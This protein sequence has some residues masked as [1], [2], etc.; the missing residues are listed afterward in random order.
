M[1]VLLIEDNINKRNAI[2]GF[3]CAAFPEDDFFTA[4][5]LISGLKSARDLEPG[6]ILLDMSL[7]NRANASHKSGPSAT[8]A[9]A[10]KEFLWRVKRM[11]FRTHVLV[12]SMFETFGVSPNIIT[13]TDLD[14]EMKERYPELYVSAVHYS[15]SDESWQGEI[16][17]FRSSLK[18]NT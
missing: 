6:A 11:N 15:P 4:D 3:Y 7:P 9:F 10:G 5:S 8:I 14:R 17:S 2:A 1:K 13:L 18:D 12:V 16:A